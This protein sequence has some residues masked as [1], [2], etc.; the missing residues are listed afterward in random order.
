[1][2][3]VLTMDVLEVLRRVATTGDATVTIT[4]AEAARLVREFENTRGIAFALIDAA[5]GTTR[6]QGDELQWRRDT[7]T[8]FISDLD[9]DGKRTVSASDHS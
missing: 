3:I 1:M 7:R 5:G 4:A 9:A 8:L 2:V 6:I